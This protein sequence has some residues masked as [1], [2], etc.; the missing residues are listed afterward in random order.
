MLE[1]TLF[2]S[3]SFLLTLSLTLKQP[4]HVEG[5]ETKKRASFPATQNWH[6]EIPQT[7]IKGEKI[8]LK[9]GELWEEGTEME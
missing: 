3:I 6:M 5:D 4:I 9:I 7:F 8:Q 1:T 2:P